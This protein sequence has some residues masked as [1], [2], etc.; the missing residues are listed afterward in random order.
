MKKILLPLFVINLVFIYIFY[1]LFAQERIETLLELEKEINYNIFTHE[2]G[3]ISYN[4]LEGNLAYLE[5]MA[6]G[7]RLTRYRQ[8]THTMVSLHN[9]MTYHSLEVNRFET[10]THQWIDDDIY[11]A[12]LTISGIGTYNAAYSF[13]DS[14]NKQPYLI[15]V[16]NINMF[17]RWEGM[18]LHID[19]MILIKN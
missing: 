14:L 2:A 9:L 15:V 10:G 18:Y 6:T 4:N 19:L 17:N 7:A 1:S 13:L 5:N 8:L 3:L 16:E 11:G 12:T